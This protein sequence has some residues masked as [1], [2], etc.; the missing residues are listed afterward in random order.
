MEK[1]REI[2][3]PIA[4]G[5]NTGHKIK[6]EGEGE[7]GEEGNRTGDLYIVL[8]VQKH[9]IFERH[10]DDDKRV[11]DALSLMYDKLCGITHRRWGHSPDSEG[12]SYLVGKA[13][14]LMFI[15]GQT[16]GFDTRLREEPSLWALPHLWVER[17]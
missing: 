11:S 15:W 17:K 3:V 14:V 2:T 12:K 16:P 9:P 4:R 6:I 7:Q 13:K 5:A 1:A 10:G 8:A